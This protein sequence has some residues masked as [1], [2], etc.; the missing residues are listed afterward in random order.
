MLNPISDPYQ[1]LVPVSDAR[2]HKIWHRQGGA[3][4]L[5]GD[6]RRWLT[7]LALTCVLL[8]AKN[9]DR[10]PYR[11]LH[12]AMLSL[13]CARRVS[14]ASAMDLELR[15]LSALGWRLGPFHASPSE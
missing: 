6:D 3:P 2:P 9:L 14:P 4:R 10:V 7:A 15:V 11:G 13:T 12:A 8:A 1:T 5:M